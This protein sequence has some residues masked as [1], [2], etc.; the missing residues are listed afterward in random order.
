MK[1]SYSD[2]RSLTQIKKLDSMPQTFSI[3]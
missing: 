1:Q 2:L 3:C